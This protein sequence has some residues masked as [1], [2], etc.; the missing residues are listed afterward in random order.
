MAISSISIIVVSDDDD[1]EVAMDIAD[2]GLAEAPAMDVGIPPIARR[3]KSMQWY[4]TLKGR[5]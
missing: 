5:R 1:V 3:S 2:A 4:R